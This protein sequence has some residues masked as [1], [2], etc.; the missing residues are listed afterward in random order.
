MIDKRKNDT[1][2]ASTRPI[3]V[4]FRIWIGENQNVLH[5]EEA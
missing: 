5:E 1:S 4:K 3:L 2:F